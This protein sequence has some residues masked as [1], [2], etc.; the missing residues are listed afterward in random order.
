MA[1]GLLAIVAAQLG[2]SVALETAKPA[3]RDPE[4]GERLQRLRELREA[5]PGRPLIVALGSS[6]TQMGLRPS[7]MAL[8]EPGAPLVFNFG[9][10]GAG[11]MLELLTFERILA[12]GIKPD[13]VLVEFFPATMGK[14]DF[15]ERKVPRWQTR[16]TA[17]DLAV[18]EPYCA[19]ARSLHRNWLFNRVAPWHTYRHELLGHW[20]PEWQSLLARRHDNW[21]Q[22]DPFG[23]EPFPFEAYA[24]YWRER[25]LTLLRERYGPELQGLQMGGLA[26]RLL[27]DLAARCRGAG[28]AVAFFSI[29][30][31][32]AFQSLYPPEVRTAA[33]AYLQALSRDLGISVL[34]VNEPFAE[35]EF[36]DSHH[37]LSAG[38]ARFSRLF[39]DRCLRLWMRE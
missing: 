22:V 4:F 23:W 5:N 9:Q 7:A 21:D 14:D 31:G 15:A 8:D 24:P 6:R 12:A 38:A 28:I 32:P 39:A 19:D 27:R 3:W 26:E 20:Q 17:H 30:E 33:D 25:W 13:R 18:L 1:A 16:F 35:E 34:A 37:L 29:P 11:P 2:M 36:A 10:A